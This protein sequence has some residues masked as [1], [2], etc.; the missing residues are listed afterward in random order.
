MKTL[1]ARSIAS[2]INSS[3]S[4]EGTK[5][6]V[7]TSV[8]S[9]GVISAKRFLSNPMDTDDNDTDSDVS[10]TNNFLNEHTDDFSDQLELYRRS[11]DDGDDNDEED[12]FISLDKHQTIGRNDLNDLAQENNNEKFRQKINGDSTISKIKILS[13]TSIDTSSE[14]MEEQKEKVERLVRSAILRSGDR[15]TRGTNMSKHNVSPYKSSHSTRDQEAHF[16][17]WQPM[18]TLDSSL[19]DEEKD[20]LKILIP[21]LNL[22]E[23]LESQPI[24][25]TNTHSSSASSSSSSKSSIQQDQL[26]SSM[27]QKNKELKSALDKITE[28]KNNL[29]EQFVSQVTEMER[30]LTRTEGSSPIKKSVANNRSKQSRHLSKEELSSIDTTLNMRIPNADHSPIVKLSQSILNTSSIRPV[31]VSSRKERDL[32]HHHSKS[33]HEQ[34]IHELRDKIKEIKERYENEKLTNHVKVH[35][36]QDISDLLETLLQNELEKHEPLT[37]RTRKLTSSLQDYLNSTS[38]VSNNSSPSK[39]NLKALS[40]I[41]E[42]RVQIEIQN[43]M[44][45]S[46]KDDNEQLKEQ[47]KQERVR[48]KSTQKNLSQSEKH[49]ERLE[50]QMKRRESAHQVAV[51]ELKKAHDTLLMEKEE[52]LQQVRFLRESIQENTSSLNQSISSI[53]GT[54]FPLST[55]SSH[56]VKLLSDNQSEVS[57]TRDLEEPVKDHTFPPSTHY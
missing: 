7:D 39:N 35:L 29:E 52:L 20:D 25:A 13:K 16:E 45:E 23:S 19:S 28:E 2:S 9:F 36:T 47:L 18:N 15:K 53:R 49:I 41:K 38:A 50:Q 10:S 32:S 1:S 17:T 24:A 5:S 11:Y 21:K 42:L 48:T 14:N 54:G 46:L 33:G 56:C 51:E 3:L 22:R 44:I 4:R 27:L 8:S 55:S 37:E 57:C 30:Y 12:N 6:N 31:Q 26:L 43:S 40:E 34:T